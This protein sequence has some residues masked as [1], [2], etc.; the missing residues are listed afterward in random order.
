MSID[1]RIVTDTISTLVAMSEWAQAQSVFAAA[2]VSSSAPEDYVIRLNGRRVARDEP[3]DPHRVNLFTAIKAQRP[4]SEEGYLVFVVNAA[5]LRISKVFSKTWA[6]ER[7]PNMTIKLNGESMPSDE[8]E[9]ITGD[10]LETLE[11]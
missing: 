11:P 2:V 8:V 4:Q 1:V 7:Y 9:L 5:C 10:V 3:F 6:G